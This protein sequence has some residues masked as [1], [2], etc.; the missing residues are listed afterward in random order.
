MQRHYCPSQDEVL[1]S[2]PPTPDSVQGERRKFCGRSVS[3]RSPSLVS[4][5]NG[6]IDGY[7]RDDSK[8]TRNG[9][10]VHV[11]QA[12]EV[13]CK[14]KS[15]P[16]QSKSNRGAVASNS[17][18]SNALE[19]SSSFPRLRISKSTG[20]TLN[21]QTMMSASEYQDS[22]QAAKV[23]DAQVSLHTPWHAAASGC[24][25]SDIEKQRTKT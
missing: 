17:T 8:E 25:S 14:Q 9:G 1:N 16:K 18:R 13:D 6:K 11:P 10:S 22:A 2:K 4:A 23:V 19:L 3:L 12:A 5:P 15:S 24:C 20:S 7:L 21:R